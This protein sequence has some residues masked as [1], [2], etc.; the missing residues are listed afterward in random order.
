MQ[1]GNK[2]DVWPEDVSRPC[3]G[4]LRY[5]LVAGAQGFDYNIRR[6]YCTIVAVV[7][8]PVLVL[9]GV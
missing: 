2:F 5:G 3:G 7:R 9:Y 4:G 6:S 1:M 8:I